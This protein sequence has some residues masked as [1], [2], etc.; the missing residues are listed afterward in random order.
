MRGSGWPGFLAWALVGMLWGFTALAM[1]S[2][3]IFILPI[4]IAATV[5]V[6][7][8][9]AIWPDILG[10]ASAPAFAMGFLAWRFWSNAKCEANDSAVSM[11][12]S[13]GTFSLQSGSL[14]VSET[15]RFTACTTLDVNTLALGSCACIITA[16]VAYLLARRLRIDSRSASGEA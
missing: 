14:S 16:I 1:M 2:I 10:L 7:R 5:L 3:G 11:S 12:G 9:F 15:I 6:A 13:S 8:R 4:A